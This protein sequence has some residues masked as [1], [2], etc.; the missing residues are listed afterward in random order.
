M[1]ATIT[2]SPLSCN[3]SPL[4]VNKIHYTINHMTTWQDYWKN[5][6]QQKN[7]DLLDMLRARGGV[8]DRQNLGRIRAEKKMSQQRGTGIGAE[9]NPILGKPMVRDALGGVNSADW[10]I[11]GNIASGTPVQLMGRG[12]GIVAD[13][14]P[15]K[16]GG[17]VLSTGTQSDRTG[18]LPTGFNFGSGS[19][20]GN[21]N[22]NSED[23]WIAGPDGSCTMGNYAKGKAPVGSFKT[24]AECRSAQD[25]D[26][27][28]VSGECKVVLKG[29]G[30]YKSLA[31]C[32]AKLEKQPIIYTPPNP[33]QAGP[34]IY[35]PTGTQAWLNAGLAGN[36][37]YNSITS[38][39]DKPDGDQCIAVLETP[40]GNAVG[41][42]PLGT[43]TCGI[44]EYGIYSEDNS[45][46]VP[47][48]KCPTS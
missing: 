38:W 23:A 6:G 22:S 28:C 18:S 15:S 5:E 37:S 29:T 40:G 31:E 12:F 3:N 42:G 14:K 17:D 21:D 36:Y 9:Y 24:L 7:Q 34:L 4:G 33:D 30:K 27:N 48:R 32:K 1:L 35:R 47:R 45:N 43:H 41:S 16:Q 10:N 20:S 2:P 13:A 26:Y 19:G 25:S 39:G 44:Y 8:Y 11:G 46:L